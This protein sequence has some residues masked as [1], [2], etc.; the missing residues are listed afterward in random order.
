MNAF[1]KASA[2]LTLPS[3]P[4]GGVGRVRGAYDGK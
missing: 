1:V 4:S 2:P 3:P